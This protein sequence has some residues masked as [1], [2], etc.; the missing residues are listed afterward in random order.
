MTQNKEDQWYVGR[1]DGIQEDHVGLEEAKCNAGGTRVS[2]SRDGVKHSQMD[3]MIP[4]GCCASG[5]TELLGETSEVS[6]EN[7]E[8]P[9][10]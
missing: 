2:A 9:G 7:D 8:R 10:K 6:S 3:A 4:F 1:W 5:A